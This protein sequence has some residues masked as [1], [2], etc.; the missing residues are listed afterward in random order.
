MDISSGYGRYGYGSGLWIAL[1]G[2][3]P[4]KHELP[5]HQNHQPNHHQR[6]RPKAFP[7]MA[8]GW[9]SRSDA[10]GMT[11][12]PRHSQQLAILGW[13]SIWTLGFYG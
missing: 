4:Y 13:C 7:A 1:Y 11:W 6:S 9:P 5:K 10:K 8:G 12:C 2:S 3:G